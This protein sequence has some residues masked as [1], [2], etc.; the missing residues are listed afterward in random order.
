M[1]T[2][3]KFQVLVIAFYSVILAISSGCRSTKRAV[4]ANQNKQ[5]WKIVKEN[6]SEKDGWK[7][8]SRKT[9]GTDVKEF[10]VVGIIKSAPDICLYW[11]KDK[12]IHSVKY[13][14]EESPIEI[15]EDNPLGLLT[16]SVSKMPWPIKDRAMCE[17]YVYY[18][19]A[20]KGIVGMRWKEAW[21][22]YPK[23]PNNKLVRMPIIRGKWEFVSLDNKNTKAIYAA[24]F[25]PGKGIPA[26]MVNRM[27]GKFLIEEFNS[28][29][30]LSEEN[31]TN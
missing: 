24:Q 31:E 19:Q 18:Q 23:P 20:D 25:D 12:I 11:A 15:L 4:T 6:S 9:N 26:G 28:I 29:K 1:K 16:Y 8:Y 3:F 27:A 13:N 30:H 21:E 2:R 5:E 10:K 7:L 22:E 14:K 17:R